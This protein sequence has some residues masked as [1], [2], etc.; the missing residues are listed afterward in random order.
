MPFARDDGREF[1]DPYSK[2]PNPVMLDLVIWSGWSVK[3]KPGPAPQPVLLPRS[4]GEQAEQDFGH[5]V[6]RRRQLMRRIG[7]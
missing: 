5:H 4:L 7:H 3:C 2:T 6:L 1:L